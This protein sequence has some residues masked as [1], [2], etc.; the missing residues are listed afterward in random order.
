MVHQVCW[1]SVE[2][3]EAGQEQADQRQE[4]EQQKHRSSPGSSRIRMPYGT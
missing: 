1:G 2:E 3:D 4:E